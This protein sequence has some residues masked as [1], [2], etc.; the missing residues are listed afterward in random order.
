VT[1]VRI[2]RMLGGKKPEIRQADGRY[3]RN[4]ECEFTI[5]KMWNYPEAFIGNCWWK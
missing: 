5:R 4:K 3:A 2:A 1:E